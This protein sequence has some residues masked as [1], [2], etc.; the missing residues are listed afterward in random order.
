[1]RS[2]RCQG[3]VLPWKTKVTKKKGEMGIPIPIPPFVSQHPVLN[4]R[5]S[6]VQTVTDGVGARF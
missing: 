6:S 2:P 1:M 5:F 4:D 3:Y